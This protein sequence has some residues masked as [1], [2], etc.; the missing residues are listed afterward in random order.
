MRAY[1]V[2][3]DGFL[4]IDPVTVASRFAT[5]VS[6]LRRVRHVSGTGSCAELILP[7]HACTSPLRQLTTRGQFNPI[8]DFTYG[9]THHRRARNPAEF[10]TMITNPGPLR[11]SY[12]ADYLDWLY[13]AYRA[14]V[15]YTDACATRERVFA[16]KLLSSSLSASSSSGNRNSSNDKK[17]EQNKT[18]SLDVECGSTVLGVPPTGT[19]LRPAHSLRRVSGQL[20]RMATQRTLSDIA[21]R[22][23]MIDL[24][25]RQQQF[26]V[27]HL[28]RATRFHL[29]ELFK[30]IVL[31]KALTPSEVW[32]K[33]LLYRAILSER[34]ASYPDSFRYIMTAVD[35][36]VFAT[37]ATGKE[38]DSHDDMSMSHTRAL[39]DRCPSWSDYCYFLYLVRRYYIDNAVE[40]H[41]VLR[42]HREP[43]AARLLFTNPPPAT[44]PRCVVRCRRRLRPRALL[45]R[46]PT[47]HHHPPPRHRPKQPHRHRRSFVLRRR[48]RRL[49]HSGA[50]K[51]M[52]LC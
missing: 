39:Q 25:E 41:V 45:H 29:V 19:F 52:S 11:V 30:E 48:T 23:G 16:G 8:H 47:H 43:H 15:R 31:D 17:G 4:C 34:R 27:I 10:A 14:K 35:D 9:I 37:A 38:E 26:P 1:T 36:T 20:L 50:A 44:T 3:A 28:D 33:A 46:R 2:R 40:G 49:R 7:A 51:R 18:A 42:C 21:R 24:F 32:D 13:R 6:M 5:I 12:S 22:Q